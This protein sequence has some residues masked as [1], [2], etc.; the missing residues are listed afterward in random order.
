MENYDNN[1]DEFIDFILTDTEKEVE[2]ELKLS[3]PSVSF[4]KKERDAADKILLEKEVDKMSYYACNRFKG[5]VRGVCDKI[6]R[7]GKWLKEKDGLDM[8]PIIDTLLAPDKTKED[9]NPK[10]QKPLKYLYES[11]K[12]K[13]ITLKD[14]FYTSQRLIGKELVTDENGEWIFV[15]KLNTSWSDLAELLT[16]LLNR[17]G[18]MELVKN[19]NFTELKVYLMD[20]RKSGK[21]TRNK[22]QTSHLYRLLDKYFDVKEYRDFTNNTRKN[23]VIGDVVEDLTIKLLEKQGFKLLYHGSN[24][25]FIDMVY[26]ID[27]IMELEG[28]VFFIQVK[29]KANAAKM[30]MDYPNYKYIDLF[31]GE[32]P[33]NNGIMLYDRDSMKDGEFIAKDILQDNLDYLINKYST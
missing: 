30:A 6:H 8:Q 26:G 23:T 27:M 9:V 29:S 25:D 16:E 11:K 17:G 32:T 24:G 1:M 4:E 15:N 21:P 28:E 33:D 5:D 19:M 13:D 3:H 12:F 31:A 2:R 7:M 20:L 14:G 10:F 22:P 18:G